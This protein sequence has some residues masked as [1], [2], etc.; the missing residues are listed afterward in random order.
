[1]NTAFQKLWLITV[2]HVLIHD[3]TEGAITFSHRDTYVWITFKKKTLINEI[4]I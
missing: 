2:I 4:I 1:M 3:L